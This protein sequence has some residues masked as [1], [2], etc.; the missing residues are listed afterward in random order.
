VYKHFGDATFDDMVVDELLLNSYEYNYNL[1][2]FYSNAFIEI[3]EGRHRVP[4]HIA[5]A[6]SSSA[7]VYFDP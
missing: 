7:P 3:D 5:A 6:A 1:P 2:R 4:I